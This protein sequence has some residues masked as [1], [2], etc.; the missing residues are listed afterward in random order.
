VYN[1]PK[2]YTCK[3]IG[4]AEGKTKKNAEN[5]FKPGSALND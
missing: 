5:D 1:C 3:A 4:E 2:I